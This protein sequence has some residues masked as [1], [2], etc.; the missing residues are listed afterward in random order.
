M[1]EFTRDKRIREHIANVKNGENLT[2]QSN[3]AQNIYLN[4]PGNIKGIIDV[5][6]FNNI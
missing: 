6:N 5:T 1:F 4:Y 2:K 3:V